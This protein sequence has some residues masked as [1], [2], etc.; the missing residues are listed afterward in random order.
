MFIDLFYFNLFIQNI[1]HSKFKIMLKYNSNMM[2]AKMSHLIELYRLSCQN[3]YFPRLLLINKEK[4]VTEICLYIIGIWLI[5]GVWLL[6]HTLTV[7]K[8]NCKTNL[9][10]S[11]RFYYSI[12]S[13]TNYFHVVFT[14]ENSSPFATRCHSE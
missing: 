2:L 12:L 11:K 10:L 7:W 6:T 5:G 1:I 8:L 3:S 4:L 13:S 9:A 14:I